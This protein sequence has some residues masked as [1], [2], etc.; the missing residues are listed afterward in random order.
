MKLVFGAHFN[1]KC[2][3]AYCQ[4]LCFICKLLHQPT[5]NIPILQ[6]FVICSQVIRQSSM[7]YLTC[8]SHWNLIRKHLFYYLKLVM[9]PNVLSSWTVQLDVSLCLKLP[10][11][12]NL[13]F[14]GKRPRILLFHR[15]V[16]HA[17]EWP[18]T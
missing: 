1:R 9:V 16:S 14:I 2:S 4:H 18:L 8:H 17:R 11:S 10:H 5:A 15:P 7:Y 3:P 6:Y 13:S 12:H